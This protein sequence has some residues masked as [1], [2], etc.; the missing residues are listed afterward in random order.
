MLT[1]RRQDLLKTLIENYIETAQPVASS[2]LA[3]QFGLSPATIRN[4]MADLE[5][6][7]FIHS[8]HTS[9]GRIPTEQ[10]YKYYIQ[11]CLQSKSLAASDSKRIEDAVGTDNED[12]RHALRAIARTMAEVTGQTIIV[13]FGK[14]DF[15]YTGL[16]NLF[17]QPEFQDNDL[18]IRLSEI[19]DSMDAV[20]Q[21]FY[22]EIS[23]ELRIDVGSDNPFHGE[24]ASIAARLKNESAVML[25]LGPMR[26]NYSKNAHVISLL[27]ELSD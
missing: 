17:S 2:V 23:K 9:S 13:S 25:L 11:N 12:Q 15:Y 20:M 7:G 1:Q 16:T 8:P 19:I 22:N 24:C 10:A 3:G 26:M 27:Q 14:N 4:E 6:D 21:Q 18:V 5:R